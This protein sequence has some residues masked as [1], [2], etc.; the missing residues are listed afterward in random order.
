MVCILAGREIDDKGRIVTNKAEVVKTLAANTAA[1]KAK[2]ENPYLAHRSK[3]EAPVAV[4]DTAE[5]SKPELAALDPRLKGGSSRDLR[6]KKSFNFVE[7]GTYVKEADK[8]RQKEERKVIA[9]YSSGRKR[10]D[11]EGGNKVDD[12]AGDEEEDLSIYGHGGSKVDES[13]DKKITVPPPADG[14]VVPVMEW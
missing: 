7:E 9:G 11:Q 6:A 13:N 5:E 1:M 8:I 12:D 10:P 4:A 3:A 2:K 14:G